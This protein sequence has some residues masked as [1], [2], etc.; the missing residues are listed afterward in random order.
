MNLRDLAGS[1]LPTGQIKINL[2]KD[3][4]VQ[5]MAFETIDE[6]P[7]FSIT[8]PVFDVDEINKRAEAT[9]DA[10]YLAAFK[11]LFSKMLEALREHP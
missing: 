1:N 10:V 8:V 9:L 6:I 5:V 2:L 7:F 11:H 3:Q 4:S